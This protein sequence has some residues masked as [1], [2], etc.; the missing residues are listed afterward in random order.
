MTDEERL[1]ALCDNKVYVMNIT[2]FS[3][4]PIHPAEARRQFKKGQLIRLSRDGALPAIAIWAT[5]L[6][7]LKARVVNNDPVALAT[8]EF[9]KL[10][11]HVY[12]GD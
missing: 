8:L 5:E 2:T 6:E 4:D 12:F 1:Q 11:A 10:P 7:H 9:L 3:L